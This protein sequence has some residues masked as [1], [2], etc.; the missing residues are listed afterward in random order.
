MLLS[1]PA[2]FLVGEDA[3]DMSSFVS[4]DML[5]RVGLPGPDEACGRLLIHVL[6]NAV[7]QSGIAVGVVS[8]MNCIVGSSHGGIGEA[9]EGAGKKAFSCLGSK[10]SR[11]AVSPQLSSSKLQPSRTTR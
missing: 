11:L 2:V 4:M 9:G 10:R 7:A 5:A 6:S 1:G 3:L 8:M